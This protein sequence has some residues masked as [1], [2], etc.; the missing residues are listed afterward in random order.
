MAGLGIYVILVIHEYNACNFSEE[1][2]IS[3]SATPTTDSIDVSWELIN[4]TC[5]EETE[6]RTYSV[7]WTDP[8]SNKTHDTAGGTNYIIDSLLSCVEY[9]I[10]VGL[11][12]TSITANISVTTLIEGKLVWVKSVR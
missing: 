9:F 6:N 12:D 10:E 7:S 3:L 4:S 2:D 5:D 1:G 11:E 8:T